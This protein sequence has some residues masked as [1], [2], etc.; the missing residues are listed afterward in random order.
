[1]LTGQGGQVLYFTGT[2]DMYP[3]ASLDAV[4]D[5]TQADAEIQ[6]FELNNSANGFHG[7]TILK[8]PGEFEDED[9]E[10]IFNQ[11][12]NDTLGSSSP[13]IM[14]V[15]MDYEEMQ[16]NLFEGIP[17]DNKDKLFETTFKHI[18]RRIMQNYK[19]PPA[20][21]GV[22]PEGA[23]F[24]Q[25][26]IGDS[27]VYYNSMTKNQRKVLAR[28]FNTWGALWHE[29]AVDFGEIKEQEFKPPVF[30]QRVL[31]T[32]ET[33]EEVPVEEEVVEDRQMELNNIYGVNRYGS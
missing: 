26:E 24:N 4:A 19:Q 18:D 15:Q 2:P 9:E 6:R 1:V 10:R 13:G 23:V 11:K 21:R 32:P 14:T 16:S 12:V 25:Q 17:A 7:A 29:G 31:N 27:F 20:L 30:E 3:L 28:V 8:T 5:S 33:T 22:S